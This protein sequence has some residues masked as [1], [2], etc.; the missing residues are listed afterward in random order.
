MATFPTSIP[1]FTSKSTSNDV[2]G[3]NERINGADIN[4]LQ[5][6]LAAALAKI[7]ADSSAV[8][9]SHDYKITQLEAGKRVFSGTD[10]LAASTT[11]TVTDANC[12]ADSVVVLYPTHADFSAL[13]VYISDTSAGSF[14]L[15][16]S[17]A[18]GD[19]TFNYIIVKD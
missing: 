7:G 16:H 9:T 10:T 4:T 1:S 8:A 6:E 15:T 5:N 3:D 14:T 2:S 19:E 13:L 11:T 17:S 18:D 12:T